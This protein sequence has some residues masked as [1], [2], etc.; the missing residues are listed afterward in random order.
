MN[1]K[2][3]AHTTHEIHQ[4]THKSAQSTAENKLIK[5]ILHATL[6]EEFLDYKINNHV[7]TVDLKKSKNQIFCKKVTSIALGKLKI[8]DDVFLIHKNKLH[9]IIS[10]KELLKIIYNEVSDTVDAL[11]WKQFKK[12]I[13]NCILNESLVIPHII[14]ERDLIKQNMIQNNDQYFIDYI[15][16]NYDHSEQLQFFEFLA[17]DGHPYH[18]C[19]KT[20]LGFSIN[21]YLT[22]SPEFHQDINL[23]IGAISK[24]IIQLAGKDSVEDYQN[25]FSEHFPKQWKAWQKKLKSE[26]MSI[27][28]Y[29]PFFAHPWQYKK[30]IKKLFKDR[31]EN[32]DLKFFPSITLTVKPSLSF[33]TMIAKDGKNLPHIKLPVGV[34]STSAMRTITPSSV[35]NGPVFYEVMK[36][37]FKNESNFENNLK[38]SNEICGLYLKDMPVSIAKNC[39]IIFR[40]N[41]SNLVKNSE[42]PIVVAAL[43]ETSP[44]SG[45]PLFIEMIHA[46]QGSALKDAITYF[47][48]YCRIVLRSYFDIFML[49]GC[50]LEGHQQNTISVFENYAPKFM[51]VRD[52]GGIRVNMKTLNE[53]GIQFDA[54]HESS[55][56]YEDSADVTATFL[57]TVLQY[58]LG[59]LVSLLSTYYNVEEKTFWKVIRSNLEKR[60]LALKGK[61]TEERWNT[62]YSAILENDWQ[63]KGLMRMRLKND[64]YHYE[65][66]VVPNPLKDM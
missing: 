52:F 62:E 61:V 38:I 51:I 25:W 10:A 26:K 11:A 2:I 1:T 65:S 34:Y 59:E 30:V 64:A 31:I 9:Q 20:K 47:D 35:H 36:Q 15:T 24:D 32:K 39:G 27:E 58:H 28:Q 56:L 43:F 18:P 6:R 60:F 55:I 21:D 44:L 37:I 42:V 48:E 19:H 49:Y 17:V 7:L 54:H 45:L 8:E 50:A 46:S 13:E 16:K 4:G 63:M 40:K 66:I 14:K 3:E 41:P 29:C 57:H 23:P 5:R 22:Y 33:R 53:R 12:E